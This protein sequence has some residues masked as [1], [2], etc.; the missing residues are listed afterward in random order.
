MSVR[1][2]KSRAQPQQRDRRQGRAQ[3]LS[4]TPIRP[5]RRNPVFDAQFSGSQGG[6]RWLPSPDLAMFDKPING[7][8]QCR[9]LD[10]CRSPDHRGPCAS[11]PPIGPLHSRVRDRCPLNSV[12]APYAA[13]SYKSRPALAGPSSPVSRHQVAGGP[14]LTNVYGPGLRYTASVLRVYT[15][16]AS[17]HRRLTPSQAT[18]TSYI[19]AT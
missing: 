18:E 4:R 8:P 17:A 2:C 11:Q 13:N 19:R 12:S 16:L 3:G 1:P 14:V 10:Q 6:G 5:T 7:M 9:V 15:W